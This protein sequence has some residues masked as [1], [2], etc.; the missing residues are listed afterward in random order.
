MFIR[1]GMEVSIKQWLLCFSGRYQTQMS[2]TDFFYHILRNS[3]VVT[4]RLGIILK[5]FDV[6]IGTRAC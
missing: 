2:N 3:Y 4:W 6:T 5:Y 1:V